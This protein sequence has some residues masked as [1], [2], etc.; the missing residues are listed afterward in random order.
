MSINYISKICYL[1]KT[2][3]LLQGVRLFI[4]NVSKEDGYS[5]KTKSYPGFYDDSV[6]T[7]CV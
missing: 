1:E 7:C 4:E 2:C 6:F 5:E 3:E